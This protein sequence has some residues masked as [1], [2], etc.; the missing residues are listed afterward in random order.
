[1]DG[2][3]HQTSNSSARD[4]Y[5]WQ[6]G[7]SRCRAHRA[8]RWRTFWSSGFHPCQRG[9]TPAL[10]LRSTFPSQKRIEDDPSKVV[11]IGFSPLTEPVEYLVALRTT[12]EFE[13]QLEPVGLIFCYGAIHG[14]DLRFWDGSF[15]RY[16]AKKRAYLD[17]IRSDGLTS[18]GLVRLHKDIASQTGCDGS[19]SSNED[20]IAKVAQRWRRAH[21]PL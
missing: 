13:I 1:M 21:V 8:A 10:C 18:S 3:F 7:G 17:S 5:Y 11:Y 4:P 19:S 12:L 2:T 14:Q 15:H 16:C 9:V 6:R 20:L